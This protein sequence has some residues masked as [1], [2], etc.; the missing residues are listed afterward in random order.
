MREKYSKEKK[1][2]AIKYYL[3]GTGIR[4]IA[5]CENVSPPLV[6]HWIKNAGK[7]LQSHLQDIEIPDHARDID[8]LEV[9]E[10]F[11]YVQKKLA[12]YTYGLLLTGAEVKLLILK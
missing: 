7:L 10:M 4:A 9:D 8:I 6:L 2:R 1:S 11:S 5:E 3:R 12:K